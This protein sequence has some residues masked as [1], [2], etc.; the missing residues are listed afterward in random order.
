MSAQLAIPRTTDSD[1]ILR[2]GLVKVERDQPGEQDVE[3]H[4]RRAPGP[5]ARQGI[6]HP[7]HQHGE[8]RRRES[9]EASGGAPSRQFAVH[10]SRFAV[11]GSQVG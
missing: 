9:T 8:A 10:G 4:Q 7:Q 2:Q 3:E 1:N 11:R 5:F 6:G